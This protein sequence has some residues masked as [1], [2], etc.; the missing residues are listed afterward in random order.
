MYVCTYVHTYKHPYT[1]FNSFHISHHLKQP[2]NRR[3]QVLG[4]GSR[5]SLQNVKGPQYPGMMEPC[6]MDPCPTLVPWSHKSTRLELPK[7]EAWSPKVILHAPSGHSGVPSFPFFEGM[8]GIWG[9]W[10]IVERS[11]RC[12]SSR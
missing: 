4:I 10:R 11:R 7:P 5:G 6:L 9:G 2:R 12:Q 8:V 1:Q 3:T